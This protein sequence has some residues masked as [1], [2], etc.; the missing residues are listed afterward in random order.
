MCVVDG[1]LK[2]HT[3]RAYFVHKRTHTHTMLSVMPF[4]AAHHHHHYHHCLVAKCAAVV[5]SSNHIKS[6]PRV[7]SER[8]LSTTRAMCAGGRRLRTAPQRVVRS[9]FAHASR[10]NVRIVMSVVFSSNSRIMWPCRVVRGSC[11]PANTLSE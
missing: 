11:G 10:N 6:V 1:S 3:R 2:L 4:V 8:A 5:T 7:S 9:S